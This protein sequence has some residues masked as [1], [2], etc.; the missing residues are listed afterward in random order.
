MAEFDISGYVGEEAS[1][2]IEGDTPT[3]QEL[4][5]LQAHYPDVDFSQPPSQSEEAGDVEGVEG[6]VE[7]ATFRYQYGRADDAEEKFNF[8]ART[9]GPDAVEHVSDDTFVIDQSKVPLAARRE[10]GLGNS[11]KI[12][13]DKPGMSWYDVADFGGESGPSLLAALGTS[14][15]FTGV[16]TLPAMAMVGTAAALAKATDEGI[17]YL[18]G[19][20]RQSIG[21]VGSAIVMEGLINA[22]GEGIGRGVVA[23]VGKLIKGPGP[24]V[25]AG[26]VDELTEACVEMGAP[27]TTSVLHPLT[28]GAETLALRAAK[29]EASGEVTE[30]LLK[31]A[32]P[33]VG[34][35]TGKMLTGRMLKVAEAVSENQGVARANQ[36]YVTDILEDLAAGTITREGAEELLRAE[37]QALATV[38]SDTMANPK[39]QYEVAKK[40]LDQVVKTSLDDFTKAFDPAKG[41]PEFYAEGAALSASLFKAYS[42]TLYGAAR[43]TMGQNVKFDISSVIKTIDDL[44]KNNRFINWTGSLFNEVRRTPGKRMSI[45]ELQQLKA[46]LRLSAKD[47]DLVASGAQYGVQS[48]IKTIDSI[49]EKE[50][51]QLSFDA[52]RKFRIGQHPAGYVDPITGAKQGGRFYKIEIGPAEREGIRQGLKQWNNANKFYAE[53]QEQFNN[54]AVNTIVTNAKNKF[55]NSNIEVVKQIVDG[56]NAPTL[57]MYLNAVTVPA[58]QLSKLAIPGADRAISDIAALVT[59]GQ[60]K[61]ANEAIKAA[62]LQDIIPYMNDWIAKLPKDDVYV[63]SHVGAYMSRLNNVAEMARAGGDPKLLR[64]SV[65]DSLARTWI[66]QTTGR[67]R[68]A[69]GPVATPG[70]SVNFSPATVAKSFDE[71]GTDVQN[72]LFGAEN[73]NLFRGVM[74]DFYRLPEVERAGADVVSAARILIDALPKIQSQTLKSEIQT[75]RSVMD[76]VAE[77]SK[78]AVLKSMQEGTV[79]DPT[80]LLTNVLKDPKSYGRLEAVVGKEILEGPFG[81][82]DHV[83]FNLVKASGIDQAE[84]MSGAWGKNLLKAIEKQNANGAL[85]NI[86]GKETVDSLTTLGRNSVRIS[87]EALGGAGG[88]VSSTA[89]LAVSGGIAAG[90]FLLSGSKL[91]AAGG[92][93]AGAWATSRMLRAPGVLR[94]MTSPRLRKA[95]YEKAIKAGAKL[96]STKTLRQQGPLIWLANKIA[97]MVPQQLTKLAGSGIIGEAAREEVKELKSPYTTP[98]IPEVPRIEMEKVTPDIPPMIYPTEKPTA[99]NIERQRLDPRA[100]EERKLA[101]LPA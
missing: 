62:D 99:A 14:L 60:Y 3:Q 47:P 76:D 29:A 33:Q 21:E 65:R 44:E 11:G 7:D 94:L 61:Q 101:G 81:L 27:R 49:Y 2:L 92:T 70:E 4:F 93:L 9:L 24:K 15:M 97:D 1:I 90:I 23:G 30:T 42:D 50:F 28:P 91:V 69:H 18:Q 89:A 66:D 52:A 10:Y 67:A 84:V 72:L 39:T 51:A 55:F 25:E 77:Q 8:L 68:V 36:K 80:A 57:N 34:A 19:D 79:T 37:T 40:A 86:F 73:A 12:F 41:V 53:G 74:R 64:H 46:A 100:M 54:A 17:E 85:T 32:R 96:A 31:G 48:I 88:L 43:A 22:T 6:E 95:E 78:D 38:I 87:D 58:S 16:A 5:R 98:T 26:R 83:M 20:N 59:R 71:L 56:G 82:K 35:A 13:A 63:Q 45:D 75:L